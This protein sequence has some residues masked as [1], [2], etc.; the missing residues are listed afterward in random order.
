[1]KVRADKLAHYLYEGRVY[2]ARLVGSEVHVEIRDGEDPP[3]A[4]T[5]PFR[6]LAWDG[7]KI[8]GNNLTDP[9]VLEVMNFFATEFR[10]GVPLAVEHTPPRGD[11]RAVA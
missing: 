6:V 5:Q 8:V 7:E 3:D 1:M 4:Y 10:R 2:R 9:T 11:L